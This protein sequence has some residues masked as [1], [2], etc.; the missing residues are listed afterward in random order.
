MYHFRCNPDLQPQ[1]THSAKLSYTFKQKYILST[2]YSITGE[3]YTQVFKQDDATKIT[4][5]TWENLNKMG[6]MDM[7]EDN[8]CIDIIV[9]LMN[10]AK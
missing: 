1:F 3:Q 9:E 8:V 5:V 6:N 10:Y 4:I 2:G 7:T